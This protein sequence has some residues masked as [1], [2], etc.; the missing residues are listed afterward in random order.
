MHIEQFLSEIETK[1]PDIATTM[2][3]VELGIFSSNH[4]ALRRRY[5][6]RG[7][8]F[9]RLSERRIIYPKKAVMSWLRERALLTQKQLP[10]KI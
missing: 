7:P 1:I 2:Q 5:E 6:G 8:D 9:I 4:E 10:K 3:L